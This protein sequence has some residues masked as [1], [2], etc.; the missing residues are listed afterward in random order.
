VFNNDQNSQNGDFQTLKS[1]L[2][3][4]KIWAIG[5][6]KGGVGKS[7]VTANLAI[8]LALMGHKVAAIDL[9]LGGANLHTCLGVPIPDKTLSDYLSKKV[10]SLTELLTPTAIISLGARVFFTLLPVIRLKK[11]D[12]LFNIV[13]SFKSN[14]PI[15]QGIEL[16]YTLGLKIFGTICTENSSTGVA[17]L[18]TTTYVPAGTPL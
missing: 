16:N 13:L 9:D 10:R 3:G 8:C 18:S 4:P 7:L 5:G 17:G 6:G 15:A 1:P 12:M 2:G 11:F 14:T